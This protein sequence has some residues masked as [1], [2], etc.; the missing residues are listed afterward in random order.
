MLR[1]F[2]TLFFGFFTFVLS[3]F[4]QSDWTTFYSNSIVSIEYRYDDC[5]RPEDGIHKQNIHLKFT[6]LSNKSVTVGYQ[7][8][9]SYNN[10]PA[11][12]P[13]AENTFTISL[14][15]RE[16]LEGNCGLKDKRLYIFVKMLDGTS[17]SVLTAF[18]LVNIT[19]T[20]Q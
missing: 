14:K 3:A 16:V 18:D 1:F 7:K 2:A 15:P 12:K 13:G 4:G 6:N 9:T 8:S 17:Q 11:A 19:V 10:I 20:Q 5:H